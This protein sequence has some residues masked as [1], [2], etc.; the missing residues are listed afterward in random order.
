[1]LSLFLEKGI[2]KIVLLYS[3]CRTAASSWSTQAC[4]TPRAV[5]GDNNWN[6]AAIKTLLLPGIMW[7]YKPMSSH[8]PQGFLF[9]VILGV[10]SKSKYCHLVVSWKLARTK[11]AFFA[12]VITSSVY[13]H[14]WEIQIYIQPP[15]LPQTLPMWA[16]GTETIHRRMTINPRWKAELRKGK[17]TVSFPRL[18]LLFLV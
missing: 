2:F 15:S 18:L 1:M 9:A 8:F 6:G 3:H 11:K 17:T 12:E 5:L 13:T 14:T 16:I 10:Q 7:L 4:W